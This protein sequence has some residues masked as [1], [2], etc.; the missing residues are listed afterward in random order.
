MLFEIVNVAILFLCL[1]FA[2][3]AYFTWEDDVSF[4][5]DPWELPEESGD[6]TLLTWLGSTEVW[7]YLW[8][9]LSQPRKLDPT[10]CY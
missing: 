7:A 1:L 3:T 10:S 2:N 5:D 9:W 6:G 4:W 8:N